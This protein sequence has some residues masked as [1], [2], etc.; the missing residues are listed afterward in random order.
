YRRY[1]HRR[2]R[3]PPRGA[4]ASPHPSTAPAAARPSSG[5]RRSTARAPMRSRAP[6]SELELAPPLVALARQV[7]EPVE[8]LAVRDPRVLEEL[9]VDARCREARDRVQ[10]VH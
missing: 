1:A 3:P 7:D 8:Q 4:A 9:R 2:P 5:A 10:L 6:A